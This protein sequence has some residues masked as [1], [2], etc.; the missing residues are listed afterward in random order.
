MY[1]LKENYIFAYDLA[2]RKSEIVNC[3]YGS[4]MDHS[5]RYEN[6]AIIGDWIYISVFLYGDNRNERR[7]YRVNVITGDTE[8]IGIIVE[9]N[10]SLQ[11]Y[12]GN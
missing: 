6:T 1:Y 11:Y 4:D 12:T 3:S 7:V 10:G 5:Y 8:R 9:G 2:A